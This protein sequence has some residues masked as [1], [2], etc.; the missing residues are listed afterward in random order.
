VDAIE[1]AADEN[2]SFN[3]LVDNLTILGGPSAL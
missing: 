1:A 3:P 2:Y